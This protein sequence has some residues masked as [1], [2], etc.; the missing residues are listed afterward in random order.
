MDRQAALAGISD[1]VHDVLGDD[2]L[3]IAED[4]TAGPVDGWDSM[5]HMNIV[6]G[7]EKRFGLR[8]TAAELASLRT[9]GATVGQIVDLVAARS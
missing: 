1:V 7:I 4:T 8:F 3:A 6:I 2:D 9:E 5:A